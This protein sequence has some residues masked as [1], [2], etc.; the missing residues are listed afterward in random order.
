M[1]KKAT[2]RKG[3]NQSRIVVTSTM[4]M[5]TICSESKQPRLEGRNPR[6]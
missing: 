5:P 1:A 2:I 4:A 3:K 6:Q